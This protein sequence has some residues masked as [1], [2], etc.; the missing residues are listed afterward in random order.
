VLLELAKSEGWQHMTNVSLNGKV[1]TEV[2]KEF[3][4]ALPSEGIFEGSYVASDEVA[5]AEARER[6]G[7]KYFDWT[8]DDA[9]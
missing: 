8:A 4:D 9:S 1:V 5:D 2:T 6:I 7:R 3:M